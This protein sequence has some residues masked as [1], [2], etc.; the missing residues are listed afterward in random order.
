MLFPII[1]P[2]P[3]SLLHNDYVFCLQ[4]ELLPG[5]TMLFPALPLLM[6]WVNGLLFLLDELR[7]APKDSVLILLPLGSHFYLYALRALRK[8]FDV[9]LSVSS[10][11]G[12]WKELSYSYPQYLT[13]YLQSGFCSINICWIINI[14][15]NLRYNGAICETEKKKL[16]KD[17]NNGKVIL[18]IDIWNSID[19]V[20]EHHTISMVIGVCK[21]RMPVITWLQKYTSIF[22]HPVCIPSAVKLCSSCHQKVECL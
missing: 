3:L 15:K 21:W 4:S 13:S 16:P 19:F 22:I 9:I 8:Q 1:Y 5:P 2:Y 18:L 7:L 10:F 17:R 14:L 11:T 6:P 12:F 20:W